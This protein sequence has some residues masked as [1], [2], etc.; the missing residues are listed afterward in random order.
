MLP[1][2]FVLCHAK[3]D[4]CLNFG[5]NFTVFTEHKRTGDFINKIK[6]LMNISVDLNYDTIK[7]RVVLLSVSKRSKIASDIV[8]SNPFESYQ[9]KESELSDEPHL[10]I[11]I[12]H[13]A[14]E[15]APCKRFILYNNVVFPKWDGSYETLIGEDG[16]AII[17]I[18]GID[19]EYEIFV[20]GRGENPFAIF[21][22]GR[23][24]E[25]KD[26]FKPEGD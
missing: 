15:Q 21:W 13:S 6:D 2:L 26:I 1:S 3:D 19:A 9:E 25:A 16:Y 7:D 12:I 18:D 10:A 20:G 5:E 14:T 23:E 17:S 24:Y 4:Q 11:G 8:V 22:N